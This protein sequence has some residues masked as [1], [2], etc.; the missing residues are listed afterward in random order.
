MREINKEFATCPYLWE[1]STEENTTYVFSE[2]PVEALTIAQTEL[3]TFNKEYVIKPICLAD[4]I[5]NYK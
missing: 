4:K 2:T 1:V 5:I 3:N